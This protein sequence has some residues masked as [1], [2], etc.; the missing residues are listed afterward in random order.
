MII[1]KI[2]NAKLYLGLSKELDIGLEYIMKTDI[3]ALANGKYELVGHNVYSIIQEYQ[4]KPRHEG[5]LEAHKVYTDIQFIAK[6][7]EK[8]GY[9]NLNGLTPT[10]EYD[11]EKDIIFFNDN[12]DFV[13]AKAGY[14]V[15]FFPTDAHMPG[16][17]VENPSNVKKAVIK[18]K[19]KIKP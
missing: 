4:T 16:I 8:L 5:L 11:E 1:D 10:Q 12:C 19:H 18:V 6:G 9:A 3:N 2:E 14:F 15:I 13:T 17:A 7:E